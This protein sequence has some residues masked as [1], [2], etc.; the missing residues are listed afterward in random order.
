MKKKVLRILLAFCCIIL[1]FGF[2]ITSCGQSNKTQTSDKVEITQENISYSG[3]RSIRYTGEE[4]TLDLTKLTI[5]DANRRPIDKSYFSFE[6]SNN[7]NVGDAV[8][9]ITCTDNNPSLKGSFDYIFNIYKGQTSVET[10]EDACIALNSGNYS[11]VDITQSVTIAE[12]STL[13]IPEGSGIRIKEH[14]TLTNYGTI[15]NNNNIIVCASCSLINAGTLTN[16]GTIGVQ[17]Y[18]TLFT[19]NYSG[20][21]EVSNYGVVYCDGEK[22]AGLIDEISSNNPG[23]KGKSHVRIDLATA[24]ISLD[25]AVDGAIEY[26]N[27]STGVAPS[28]KVNSIA[29]V[30]N[31][32]GNIIFSNNTQPTDNAL[33]RIIANVESTKYFGAR[34]Y[35]FRILKG[36]AVVSSFSELLQKQATNCFSRYVGSATSSIVVSSDDS[37]ILEEG[38]T[39]CLG[40]LAVLGTFTNN[41]SIEISNNLEVG[42]SFINNGEVQANRL[43]CN[44]NSTLTNSENASIEV[45]TYFILNGNLSNAGNLG[46]NN[47]Q[48]NNNGL[49]SGVGIVNSGV[50]NISADSISK[51]LVLNNSGTIINSGNFILN[52][53]YKT[54]I[55]TGTFENNGF[56]YGFYG[57]EL[58][59]VENVYYR[60]YLTT[61]LSEYNSNVEKYAYVCLDETEFFYNHENQIPNVVIQYVENGVQTSSTLYPAINGTNIT[62]LYIFDNSNHSGGRLMDY[63]IRASYLEKFADDALLVS[64]GDLRLT[65]RLSSNNANFA[66]GALDR[67]SGILL[68]YSI[69]RVA[70]TV[71]NE[72][73]L[74]RLL[75]DGTGALNQNNFNVLILGANIELTNSNNATLIIRSHCT[76]SLNGHSLYLKNV[77]TG[78]NAYFLNEGKIL[79]T[80]GS[81]LWLKSPENGAKTTLE[82]SGVIEDVGKILIE[83]PKSRL[84]NTVTNGITKVN[85][86][87][88]P[89]IYAYSGTFYGNT[90]LGLN[91][92]LGGSVG[93]NVNV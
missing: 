54:F 62:S 88:N 27:N 23:I 66:L 70:K 11:Y 50:I 14:T 77:S 61:N 87:V 53:E 48:F 42:N 69:Q 47:L 41:G 43:E 67:A 75:T 13:I 58:S 5:K 60:K 52:S 76:L 73:D 46:L 36:T 25:G 85:N 65:L 84:T 83:A 7:I 86:T 1:P 29:F 89:K 44:A 15:T 38:A 33:V 20:S 63:Y 24:E 37:F 9:T 32:D 34:E 82:N 81:I 3:N 30:Q 4:I 19:G 6:Y 45:E 22:V 91:N 78:S 93:A 2:F 80:N 64:A 8:L 71:S 68:D 55:N 40:S 49:E 39:L 35:T 21:G 92:I 72:S 12:N 79:G 74:K 17:N 16:N 51:N 57:N 59:G 90:S 28:V 10:L 26:Q 56:I 18:G 31:I